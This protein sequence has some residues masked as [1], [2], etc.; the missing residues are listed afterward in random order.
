MNNCEQAMIPPDDSY[1]P[2]TEELAY[3]FEQ[4]AKFKAL[5]EGHGVAER[6]LRDYHKHTD[7]QLREANKE[8]KSIER[9]LQIQYLYDVANDTFDV[10]V[11]ADDD[12]NFIT[13]HRNGAFYDK[14][15]DP[16]T[17]KDKKRMK[18]R[19]RKQTRLGIWKRKRIWTKRGCS[20]RQVKG[21]EDK[22]FT[23]VVAAT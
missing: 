7:R 17:R 20:P 12:V 2:D 16:L 10:P 22:S 11:Y 1:E 14:D 3:L 4:N 13:V 5:C 18:K 21:Y 9:E 6:E 15:L 23:P 8:A 19:V